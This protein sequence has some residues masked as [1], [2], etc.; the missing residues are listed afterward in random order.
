[1]FFRKNKMYMVLFVQWIG[2]VPSVGGGRDQ[3]GGISRG[4]P[5]PLKGHSHGF[6][7]D[8]LR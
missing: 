2:G 6:D 5:V 8:C 1:V 7:K 3:I 4:V